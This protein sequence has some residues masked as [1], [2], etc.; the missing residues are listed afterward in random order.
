[1]ACNKK[2]DKILTKSLKCCENVVYTRKKEVI[3]HE[4]SGLPELFG[5]T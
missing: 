2:S 3:C 1:M 5:P 4:L